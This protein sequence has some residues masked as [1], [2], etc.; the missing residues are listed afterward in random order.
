MAL[1]SQTSPSEQDTHS[2]QTSHSQMYPLESHLVVSN[3]VT[4]WT[5]QS[6]DFSRPE[7]WSGYSP[8]DL[9]NPGIK[10]GSPALQVRS[11]PT[12]LSGKPWYSQGM[13][14]M[15]KQDVTYKNVDSGFRIAKIQEQFK[16][17]R[18]RKDHNFS[19]FIRWTTTQ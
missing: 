5:V 10:L 15:C 11:L 6:M 16:C 13:I 19:I 8:G 1:K 7:Y 4:P 17:H 18:V 9:P 14:H 3:S 2:K 12:E